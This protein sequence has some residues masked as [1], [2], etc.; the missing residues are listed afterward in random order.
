M[1]GVDSQ[2]LF[3]NFPLG[4]WG[5]GGLRGWELFSNYAVYFILKGPLRRCLSHNLNQKKVGKVID[6][7]K[8]ILAAYKLLYKRLMDKVLEFIL[9]FKK[10]GIINFICDIFP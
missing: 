5:G 2:V 10:K 9:Q 1:S 7:Y 8:I 3:G 6:I 4:I